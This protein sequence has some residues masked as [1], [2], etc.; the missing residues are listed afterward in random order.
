MRTS[1]SYFFAAFFTLLA[2]AAA[3]AT[4]VVPTDRD[5]VR[6]TDAIVVGEALTSYTQLTDNGGIETVTPFSI[7]ETIK[8]GF[9]S[10]TINIYE[11]GGVYEKRASMIPGVPRFREGEKVILFL[12][13]TGRDRWS[14]TDIALGK[15]VFETDGYGR[16]LAVRGEDDIVGWDPNGEPHREVRRDATK[17]LNFLRSVASGEKARLDYVV[18]Y[19]PMPSEGGR[20]RARVNITNSAT[21]YTFSMDGTNTGTGAR[22]NVFP[23][24]ITFYLAALG[25]VTVPPVTG[26]TYPAS[27]STTEAGAAGLGQTAV[28]AAMS[29]WTNN[30]GSNVRYTL[31]TGTAP[32]A[33]NCYGLATTD[34]YNTITF[35]A[36]LT[37]YG[38]P[39]FSCSSGGYNGVLG[40]GGVTSASGTH[41]G[42]NGET[43]WTTQEGDVEMNQ[44]IANCTLLLNTHAGDWN[45]ALTH[46]VGH[47][48]G[49]RH[50]DQTRADNPSVLCG[51]DGSL[52]CTSS[53]IMTAFVTS[54]LNATLATWD[55]HAATG[56]YPAG[57]AP[58]APTGVVATASGGTVT[59]TW[60]AVSGATSYT[61]WRK[62]AG[63]SFIQVGAPTTNSYSESPA[64]NAAYLYR[65]I[66]VSS[67]VSS[68]P[69]AADLTTNVIYTGGSLTGG[70]TIQAA[71]MTQLRSA[72]TA[73][74]S[75]AG[76]VGS[77]SWTY[78]TISTGSTI[79]AADVTDLRTNL[80]TAINQINSANSLSLTTGGWTNTTLTG[81]VTVK[82]TH[83]TELRSRMN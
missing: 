16:E 18:P 7:S 74:Y 10:S 63:G 12:S 69:S 56:V 73:V 19:E 34:G 21:S 75:L 23:T 20:P 70:V 1:R 80:D 62:A 6:R 37:P 68:S 72:V 65:V 11:P 2:T 22:W 41:T 36:N 49:F 17:F 61:V 48:L 77:P 26:T 53:A 15:F 81:G 66:A 67:G 57:S 79:H 40:I 42:P 32:C 14:V 31:N 30:A 55:Q 71:H 46:E 27:G 28:T 39:A 29:A 9:I 4:F 52:E 60:S 58:A 43:F 38:V 45:S 3:A 35:D 50:S 25:T 51:T 47:T 8:G 83:F 82:A 44:G 64:T 13:A 5:M 78:S 59:V 76:L 54:G 33:P 24:Q